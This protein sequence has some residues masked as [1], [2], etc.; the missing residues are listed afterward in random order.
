MKISI[1]I[2]YITKFYAAGLAILIVPIYLSIFGLERYGIIGF[3][4]LLQNLF[5]FLDVGLSSTLSRQVALGGRD[6]ALVACQVKFV[7]LG[8]AGLS[9]PIS[10]LGYFSRE[11]LVNSWLSTVG[12]NSGVVSS[13]VALIFM[14]VGVR[15]AMGPIKSIFIGREKLS[16]LNAIDLIV[17]SIKYLGVIPVLHCFSYLDPIIVF[18]AFQF[19]ISCVEY[20]LLII[21]SNGYFPFLNSSR[22]K[23][24]LVKTKSLIKFALSVAAS[25]WMWIVIVQ[26]DKFVLSGVV[27]LDLYGAFVICTTLAAGITILSTPLS[28]VIL[29]RLAKLNA[30]TPSQKGKYFNV[31]DESLEWF[32]IFAAA[33]PAFLIVFSY[34]ILLAWTKSEYVAQQASSVLSLYS[35]GNWF[36]AI[37]AFYY[38]L[39]HSQGNLNLHNRLLLAL[40]FIQVAGVVSFIYFFGVIGAG[41]SWFLVS[42]LYLVA[43]GHLVFKKH[44]N[45]NNLMWLIT[46]SFRYLACYLVAFGG[47]KLIVDSYYSRYGASEL[48]ILNLLVIFTLVYSVTLLCILLLGRK[49]RVIRYQIWK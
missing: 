6:Q 25:S 10:L 49:G 42:L 11:F 40:M 39:Q 36:M 16:Q 43:G 1:L 20:L 28:Q 18:F 26:I 13:A 5:R 2:N 34:D 32:S 14:I 47:C 41:I 45:K 17:V 23:D 22:P 27:N 24:F 38:Y 15:F 31:Y 35:S 46:R 30:A 21:L 33:I 8:F 19:V 7:V 37:A 9:I 48:E 3:Y 12:L 29:P 4:V 44:H